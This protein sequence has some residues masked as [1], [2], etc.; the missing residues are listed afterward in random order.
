MH[1]TSVNRRIVSPFIDLSHECLSVRRPNKDEC[2]NL[3]PFDL[4]MM[5]RRRRNSKNPRE[6]WMGSRDWTW[7]IPFSFPSS[8]DALLR[9]LIF[10]PGATRCTY[11]GP[12]T[13][14]SPPHLASFSV[15][16]MPHN[17]S[18]SLVARTIYWPCLVLSS[19]L[20]RNTTDGDYK[21]S[22]RLISKTI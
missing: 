11:R 2:P 8:V 20:W 10:P 9:L 19:T 3:T 15:I 13:S 1:S 4:T 17:F 6:K 12:M 7:P 18:F 22:I 14:F 16:R 5:D 21:S